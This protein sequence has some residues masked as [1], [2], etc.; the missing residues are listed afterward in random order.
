V[1]LLAALAAVLLREPV[2]SDFDV[3]DYRDSAQ[4][5]LVW[6][7]VYLVTSGLIEQVLGLALRRHPDRLQCGGLPLAAAHLV[8]LMT[9]LRIALLQPK[10]PIFMAGLEAMLAVLASLALLTLGLLLYHAWKEIRGRGTYSDQPVL[11]MRYQWPLWS[12]LLVAALMTAVSL[13]R[14]DGMT[15]SIAN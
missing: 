9:T 1:T 2:V 10:S 6:S 3:Q 12:L 11:A 5:F 8:V 15:L 13:A 14:L 4:N 7:L